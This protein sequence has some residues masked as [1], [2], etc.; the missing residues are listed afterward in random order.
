MGSVTV[1][2]LTGLANLLIHELEA[3]GPAI[4]AAL[5]KFIGELVLKLPADHPAVKAMRKQ[6]ENKGL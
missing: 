6:L 4:L 1:Y 5:E 3:Y 2:V